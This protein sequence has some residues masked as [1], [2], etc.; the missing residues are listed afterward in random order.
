MRVL[1]GIDGVRISASDLDCHTV[2]SDNIYLLNL[3]TSISYMCLRPV[4]Y[5]RI[6]NYVNFVAAHSATAYSND[7]EWPAT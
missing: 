3:E 5:L 1:D 7:V 2:L 6:T 4:N